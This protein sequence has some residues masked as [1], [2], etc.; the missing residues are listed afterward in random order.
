MRDFY[1]K[2]LKM[3]FFK[4]LFVFMYIFIYL[5]IIYWGGYN[6]IGIGEG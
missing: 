5:L 2:N 6:N 4:D 3:N 1:F